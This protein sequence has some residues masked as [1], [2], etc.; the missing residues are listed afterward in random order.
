MPAASAGIDR[1]Q[2]PSPPREVTIT[3]VG[4]AADLG[5][6]LVNFGLPLPPGFL[7][8]AAMV[9][10]YAENGTE[11]EAAV[12]SL[13]PWRIDGKDGTIRSLQIQFRADFRRPS[14]AARQ[15]RFRPDAARKAPPRSCPWTKP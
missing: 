3:L 7:S 5:K 10:V 15:G 9:R 8:D 6:E 13:E 14:P 4:R 11:I 2:P 12:R 1:P